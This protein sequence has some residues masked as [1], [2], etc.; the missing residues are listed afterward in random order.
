MSPGRVRSKSPP[1]PM[2][3]QASALVRGGAV[4]AGVEPEEE[5]RFG[6]GVGA[7]TSAPCRTGDARERSRRSTQH[8]L[9][10]YAYSG[11]LGG[12]GSTAGGLDGVCR[13]GGCD[14]T[15]NGSRGGVE[16]G[17]RARLPR[18]RSSIAHATSHAHALWRPHGAGASERPASQRPRRLPV[19]DVPH[20]AA[21]G[22]AADAAGGG[23][24]D[25]RSDP[26]QGAA[27]VRRGLGAVG[28][29][30]ATVCA[31]AGGGATGWRPDGRSAVGGLAGQSRR[32]WGAQLESRKRRRR[33]AL[34]WRCPISAIWRQCC[35]QSERAST[36]S[37]AARLRHRR[38]AHSPGAHRCGAR[39]GSASAVE[40]LRCAAAGGGL[41]PPPQVVVGG[42]CAHRSGDLPVALPEQLHRL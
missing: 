16:I 3:A 28:E 25:R 8:T 26:R 20:S 4:V 39:T 41:A 17:A 42:G 15:G 5:E 40:F 34:G 9:W 27:R 7:S 22:V 33:R 36:P 29:R 1:S 14:A 12:T 2:G 19:G 6:N 37:P 10:T 24:G 30:V 32:L 31:S 11:Y 23:V 13:P 38:R 18:R 21:S 35:P